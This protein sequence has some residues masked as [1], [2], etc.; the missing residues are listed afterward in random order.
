MP[1]R[2]QQGSSEFSKFSKDPAVWGKNGNTAIFIS[3]EGKVLG[4][5]LKIRLLPFAEYLPYESTFD[6]PDFIIPKKK[7]NWEYPGKEYTLFNLDGAK[8]GAIICWENAFPDLFRQFVK[9]GANFMLNLTNEGWFG[10][11][12]A[13][14]QFLAMCVFRSVENRISMARAA[15]TGISC[16]I[17][18]YGRITG[19][20]WKN[21]KDIFVDG[22]LTGE[23]QLSQ[24]RTF[25]NNYGNMFVY[26]TLT[27]SALFIA[28]SFFKAKK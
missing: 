26:I 13:P 10:E 14:Y 3:S 24:Q 15:N 25:Y 11:T 8:F 28:L 17:D 4:Q 20:V 5:Y 27:I 1:S 2:Y 21:N 18:P 12:A 7:R 6:W 22:Y 9:N 16:F 23:I 19:R